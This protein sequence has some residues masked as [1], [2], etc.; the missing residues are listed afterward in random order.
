MNK[1]FVSS[2]KYTLEKFLN[3]W[4]RPHT[5]MAFRTYLIENKRQTSFCRQE[6][7]NMRRSSSC[8][9]LCVQLIVSTDCEDEQ[10]I[11]C[12]HRPMNHSRLRQHRTLTPVIAYLFCSTACVQRVVCAATTALFDGN[13]VGCRRRFATMC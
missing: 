6:H 10:V 12:S 1:N 7:A 8:L 2:V 11:E 9:S 3:S 4:Q 13:L 5:L